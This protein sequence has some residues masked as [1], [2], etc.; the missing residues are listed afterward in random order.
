MEY[1]PVTDCEGSVAVPAPPSGSAV[2]PVDEPH[3]P[4]MKVIV[5][6]ANMFACEPVPANEPVA[7]VV[8]PVSCGRSNPGSTSAF[9]ST[10]KPEKVTVVG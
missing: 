7:V 5:L 10:S 1:Q 8:P 2:I 4:W 9:V 6:V 3:L